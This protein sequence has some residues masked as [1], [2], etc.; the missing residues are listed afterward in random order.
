MYVYICTHMYGV[1]YK[2]KG[3]LE[4]VKKKC[5]WLNTDLLLSFC[6]SGK[7]IHSTTIG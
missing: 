7:K 4:S 3:H 2:F 5:I 1:S 6:I